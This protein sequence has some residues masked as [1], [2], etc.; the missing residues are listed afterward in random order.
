MSNTTEPKNETS[1]AHPVP[2]RAGMLDSTFTLRKI[3]NWLALC[4]AFVFIWY[5]WQFFRLEWHSKM[6]GLPAPNSPYYS[7]IPDDCKKFSDRHS[8]F[9]NLPDS[10]ALRIRPIR[11]PDS[12]LQP[13]YGR[14]RCLGYSM[15]TGLHATDPLD[16]NFTDTYVDAGGKPIVRITVE[17]LQTYS[18]NPTQR[19]ALSDKEQR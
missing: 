7:E 12:Y 17:Y 5:V 15:L 13:G 8:W 18:Y 2:T 3:R 9:T 16:A 4:L 10:L 11:I 14:I 19:K 1:L 6:G